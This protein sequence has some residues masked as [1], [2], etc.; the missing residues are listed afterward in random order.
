M[1][2]QSRLGRAESGWSR[3]GHGIQVIVQDQA[4]VQGRVQVEFWVCLEG[5]RRCLLHKEVGAISQAIVNYE[6]RCHPL[7][8][9]L[10]DALKES[11]NQLNF[12]V[13]FP[14]RPGDFHSWHRS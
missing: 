5:R 8:N 7:N 4:G 10:L 9:T 2:E 12:A 14:R 11:N 1:G 6:Q 13:M 3:P